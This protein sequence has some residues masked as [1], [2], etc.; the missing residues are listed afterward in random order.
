MSVEKRAKGESWPF[1][2]ALAL[3]FPLAAV[4]GGLLLRF[5]HHRPLG[6][7]TWTVAVLALFWAIEVTL[8]R[9]RRGL[10]SR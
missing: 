7:A 2:L 10:R 3:L 5:T 1:W 9:V 8:E 4:L 6:A